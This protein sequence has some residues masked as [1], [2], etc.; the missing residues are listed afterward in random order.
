MI[1]FDGACKKQLGSGGFY[2]QKQGKIILAAFTYY[3]REAPTNN[4]AEMQA[5]TDAIDLFMNQKYPIKRGESVNVIGDSK[6]VIQFLRREYR[7]GDNF[8]VTRVG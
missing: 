8:F 6:L 7:P 1:Y 4:K 5:V 3:G 2:I